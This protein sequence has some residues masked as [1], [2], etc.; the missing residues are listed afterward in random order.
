MIKL[1]MAVLAAILLGPSAAAYAWKGWGAERTLPSVLCAQS[2]LLILLGYLL[3]FSWSVYIVAAISAAAWIMALL[4]VKSVKR[5]VRFFSLPCL[6][7]ILSIPLFYYACSKRVYYSY[8]E[9]SHWGLIVK[10]IQ[11]FDELPRAGR[12]APLLLFTYP[13]AG[14]MMPAL[15]G[16][17]FGYREAIAY[18]GY[19]VLTAGMMIGLVPERAKGVRYLG[20]PFVFLCMM[21]FFPLS[22]L[23]LFSEPVIGILAALLIVRQ[24]GE[25][26]CFDDVSD[27][28]YAAMLAMMKNT[29]IVVLAFMLLARLVAHWNREEGKRCLCMLLCAAMASLSYVVYCRVQGIAATASPSH[30]AENFRALIDGTLSETYITL[31]QRFVQFFMG[32]KLS[33]AGVYTAYGFGTCATVYAF[34]LVLSA[35]HT[36]AS[37]DR[38]QALKIWAGIWISNVLY[39]LMVVL[40]YYFFFEEWEVARLNEA[41]R[42]MILPALWTGLM[43]CGLMLHERDVLR[44]KMRG[45]A[46]ALSTL[47]FVPMS[48]MDMTYH[49]FVTRDYAYRTIWAR[50]MVDRQTAL[51]KKH[52]TGNEEERL[53]CMGSYDFMALRYTMA[54]VINL[55]LLQERW[56]EAPWMGDCEAVRRELETGG[57]THVF[58]ANTDTIDITVSEYP[59]VIDERYAPL[60]Q[61]GAMLMKNS[62][63]RVVR[64]EAGKISLMYLETIPDSLG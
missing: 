37:A 5:A 15:A 11:M 14:A 60:T 58:V 6:L 47:C 9:H 59:G 20:I 50:E 63:Y 44:G 17:L 16:M 35:V 10:V 32:F 38:A 13:P 25:R 3:P 40:S 61:D 53:M 55:G 45:A 4:K 46:I 42:Y 51:L 26:T 21:T 18:V 31:P 41:D 30:L 54:D 36:A 1:K 7:F 2:L 8:D 43:Y 19:G 29:G 64:D 28:L 62:L 23:R 52:L 33:Q 34:L 12:G 24:S 48:H 57:Y 39:A 22:F 56:D 49:T 27:C